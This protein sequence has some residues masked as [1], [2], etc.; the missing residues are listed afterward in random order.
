MSPQVEEFTHFSPA[1]GLEEDIDFWS[2]VHEADFQTVQAHFD[3][4]RESQRIHTLRYRLRLPSLGK[5]IWVEDRRRWISSSTQPGWFEGSW[6]DVSAEA[7]ASQRLRLEARPP[8]V[9][10]GGLS[11]GVW[12]CMGCV[13]K[14]T[15]KKKRG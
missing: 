2:C 1:R 11:R 14:K 4:C 8:A 7:H 13:T 5:I 15:M 10:A 9:V 6:T 12:S 3:Q